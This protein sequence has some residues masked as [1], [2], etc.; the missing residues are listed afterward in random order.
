MKQFFTFF[1][2][3]FLSI[4]YS[5]SGDLSFKNALFPVELHFGNQEDIIVEYEN[6]NTQ[7]SVYQIRF[8]LTLVR[9]SDLQVMDQ[10]QQ[11]K[12]SLQPGK[13]TQVNF[14][15][16][17]YTNLEPDTEYI[18]VFNTQQEFDEDPSNNMGEHQLLLLPPFDREYVKGQVDSYLTENFPPTELQNTHAYLGMD[19]YPAGTQITTYDRDEFTTTLEYDSWLVL[20]DWDIFSKYEKPVTYMILSEGQNHIFHDV[21]WN[22]FIEDWLWIPDPFNP[23][24]II[25]GNPPLFLSQTIEIDYEDPVPTKKTDSVCA[26][27]VTGKDSVLQSALDYDKKNLLWILQKNGKGQ[28]LSDNNVKCLNGGSKAEIKAAIEELKKNYKKIY[29]YYTGHGS[30]DGKMCTNDSSKNWMTYDELFKDLF[31]TDATEIVVVVDACYAGK[32]VAAAENNKEKK[33]KKVEVFTSSDSNKT[34]RV[35]WYRLVA[36]TNVKWCESFF[37][38]AISKC[39]NDTLA[40]TNKD[41]II[42]FKEAFDWAKKQN[43]TYGTDSLNKRQNPQSFAADS[44]FTIENISKWITEYLNEKYNKIDLSKVIGYIYP[45]IIPKGTKIET[46]DTDE[47]SNILDEDTWLVM[48]DWDPLSKY[49]KPVQYLFFDK[50]NDNPL[51]EDVNWFPIVG[52]NPWNLDPYGV[53]PPPLVFG[54]PPLFLDPLLPPLDILNPIN[55]PKRDS[56]CAIIVTGK[57]STMQGAFDYDRDWIKYML[58]K[59]KL[60]EELGDDNIQVINKG[61]KA[62]IIAAIKKLKENYNKIYFFYAGH[63]S[64]KGKICTNDPST[65]W[66]TYQDLFKELYCTNASEITVILDA[67]FSGLAVS[68]AKNDTT[69]AGTK[70]RVF[71]ASDSTKTSKNVWYRSTT[72]TNNRWC[73]GFF[74]RNF[75][76]CSIDSNANKN[77]D[78]IITA[79]EAFDWTIAQ[80]PTYGTDSLKKTQNPQKLVEDYPIAL[81]IESILKSLTQSYY[82]K[83]PLNVRVYYDPLPVPADWFMYPL[84]QPE[85]LIPITDPMY[86]G[87][88]D[89][90]PLSRFE[91][92]TILFT[93][94]PVTEEFNTK[95]ANWYPV[96]ESKTGDKRFPDDV[97]LHGSK[98]KPSGPEVPSTITDNVE[99]ESKDSVCAIL[100]SGLDKKKA[101]QQE[102][103]E[104]DIKDFAENLT[105]EK[106]GAQLGDDNIRQE[107][108]IGKDSICAI[109]EGMVGKYK[110]VYFYYTGHGSND[111]KMCTGD[112]TSDWLSYDDLMKKLSDIGADDN[113]VVIDACFSGL[114]KQAIKDD[115]FEDSDITVVTSANEKK[116]ANTEYAGPSEDELK[117]YGLFSHH[118]LKCY[119]E[120]EADENNDDH[121]DFGEAYDWVIEQ[122]KEIDTLQCPTITVVANGTINDIKQEIKFKGT[123]VIVQ[124]VDGAE[125]GFTYK[126]KMSIDQKKHT[127]T[128]KR[129]I[130]LSG[131]RMWTLKSSGINKDFS[132]DLIFQL[133][134]QYENL[135]PELPNIIGM[136]W[137][138]DENDEWKPQY[139]SVHNKN[140]NTVLCGNTDHFSDWVAG[141]IVPQ[142]TNNV[143]SK[144]LINGVE[145]GPNP[146]KNVLNFEFSLDKPESFSI[147]VVDITGRRFDF[148]NTKDY[149]VGMFSVNLDGSKYPSGTYYCRMIS[150][151]GIRTIKLVKE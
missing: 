133:R 12:D 138:E 64:K 70:I 141:I 6:L 106:L 142:G 48:I 43:P 143:D 19:F 37:T 8:Q 25:F 131:S 111:G 87:W 31:G 146:F 13:T 89:L 103:F 30:K 113:C 44:R 151:S 16:L 114:A 23:D 150:D 49:S 144:F 82:D 122:Q 55:I 53:N 3:I 10:R 52:G 35:V 130:E 127:F 95:D 147:E 81:D 120:S 149:G 99:G 15:A 59:N 60:G 148:I 26:I 93:Y 54:E 61:T 58:Q 42:T 67:C 119:G 9:A 77:K 123:D 20:I 63:G 40:N 117:G 11:P 134:T 4:S 90:Q 34:S 5:Y 108:G 102:A 32:A 112:S 68:A 136:C 96:L 92:P 41:T 107:K 145:Y 109:L 140:N 84:H 104:C 116:S 74:T 121:V 28:E 22:P 57:D 125:L 94:N 75:V 137:R 86:V 51:I 132:V 18:L 100:V 126:S 101:R 7:F 98:D 38:R 76:L 88:I 110:K 27:I 24:G 17:S 21:N 73:Q 33:G 79:E 91:H 129:I 85:L 65:N 47:Y 80:N 1:A 135:I 71:T 56:V 83:D 124:G 115:Q 29:F 66:L 46:F 69:K 50:V 39:S 118:F 139:P 2:F 105:S 97:Q 62:E 78:T 45:T 128:D 36:D 14:G 72:D